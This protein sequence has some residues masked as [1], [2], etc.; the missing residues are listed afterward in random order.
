MNIT[1]FAGEGRHF[2]KVEL[3]WEQISGSMS[4]LYNFGGCLGLQERDR[5]ICTLVRR[6]YMLVQ[7][8]IVGHIVQNKSL[9]HLRND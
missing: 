3:S 2:W 7:K 6:C 5:S 4:E 8:W 9:H 1:F